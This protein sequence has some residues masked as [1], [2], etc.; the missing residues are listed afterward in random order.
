MTDTTSARLTVRAALQEQAEEYGFNAD[1]LLLDVLADAP[2]E[3]PDAGWAFAE[4]GAAAWE[5]SRATAP[6]WVGDLSVTLPSGHRLNVGGLD[7]SGHQRSDRL[8]LATIH[9]PGHGEGGAFHV[10]KVT[11]GGRY[12]YADAAPRLAALR[13][14]GVLVGEYV[15]VRPENGTGDD[16][17]QYAKHTQFRRGDLAPMADFEKGRK[18][19]GGKPAKR[20]EA[21]H[22][23]RAVA[24]FVEG[25]CE[26][27]GIDRCL[28]YLTLPSWQWYARAASDQL[29]DRLA[30]CSDLM[31]A[32]YPRDGNGK[33]TGDPTTWS[34]GYAF[35]RLE[36]AAE[37][38]LPWPR[39][40]I[41]QWTGRGKV[42]G[43]SGKIDRNLMCPDYYRATRAAYGNA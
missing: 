13:A 28:V 16:L 14:L 12:H 30:K 15:F 22:N 25:M 1:P 26:L 23:V 42:E 33:D 9:A 20:A 3:Q 21:D 43:Y 7:T 36:R 41:W 34:A 6:A 4:L 2:L 27:H 32:E 29:L 18:A 11:E 39:P 40:V 8:D 17:R 24:E 38:G 19:P 5:P 10:V 37:D 31:W 35:P